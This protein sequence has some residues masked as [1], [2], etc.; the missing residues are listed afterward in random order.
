[1]LARRREGDAADPDPDGWDVADRAAASDL[2]QL[3]V[4]QLL[5]CR[6][7]GREKVERP[8]S[9]SVTVVR[10]TCDKQLPGNQ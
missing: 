1:V 9:K 5:T 7:A 4:H 2:S 10:R 3:G 6:M 8:M